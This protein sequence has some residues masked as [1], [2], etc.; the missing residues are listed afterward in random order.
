ML[1]VIYNEG[2]CLNTHNDI[3]VYINE[4]GLRSAFVDMSTHHF[5]S[6][7]AEYGYWGPTLL[8]VGNNPEDWYWDISIDYEGAFYNQGFA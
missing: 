8:A 6:S 5:C 2:V 7:D 1:Y 3:T 4:T